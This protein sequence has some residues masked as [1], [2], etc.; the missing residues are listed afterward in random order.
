VLAAALASD[1]QTSLVV[2][3]GVD[4]RIVTV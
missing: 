2:L 4:E 1:E 3:R